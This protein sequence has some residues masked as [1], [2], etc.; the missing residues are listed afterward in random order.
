[1]RNYNM[2]FIRGIAVLCLVYMNGYA[3]GLGDY[4]YTPL[5]NPP[6]SDAVIQTL[7]SIFIDGRFRTLFSLLFGAGLFIQWQRYKSTI[8]IKARLYWL[9]IFGLAHGF[10]LWA[11][12]ILFVYGVCGWWVLKY[13]D[14]N[15]NVLLQ[16]G[17][18]FMLLTCIVNFLFLMH[19]PDESIYRD[20]KAFS[21]LYNPL[22]IDYFIS[23]LGYN[24]LAVIA[25]PFL[26]FFM[27]AGIMLIGMYLYK[28][29][30]FSRGLTSQ[31]LFVSV[32]G[33][34]TFTS[35]R[36]L[37]S[38]DNDGLSIAIQE[39]LNAYAALFVAVL[40]IHLIVKLCNNRAH[41]GTLI[42]QAG[43]LAFT[44]YISQTLMQLLLYKVL[45]PHWALSFN[46]IDYW[47]VA[48]A[49]VVVQL[50]FTAL[51]SRFYTQGPLEFI[52]RK[53]TQAKISA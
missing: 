28:L 19:M 40:Y 35:L 39:L 20:S 41:V 42:Q 33:A 44:L 17:I 10:L 21:D 22:Y 7:S 51:Y 32:S 11:G 52:W 4:T 23:N 38:Q 18:L 47:L 34:L 5:A 3:F 49:L 12:D 24:M 25:V 31:Q 13:L 6:F 2:D 48:T 46:R 8:S 29:E 36:L 27:F 1:M 15:N 9:I 26:A 14:S 53:L 37:V 43:R 50:L 16:K 30:V 45:F